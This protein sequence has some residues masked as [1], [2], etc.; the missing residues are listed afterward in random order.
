V[1]IKIDE[2][3]LH[4][5]ENKRISRTDLG[6]GYQYEEDVT[7]TTTIP[8]E[9][10]ERFIKDLQ[11]AIPSVRSMLATKKALSKGSLLNKKV[12]LQAELKAL[13]D[14]LEG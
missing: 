8:L 12:K 5:L 6:S 7:L 2:N 9:S 3:G 10:A 14:Q 4:L 13:E 11:D 1:N